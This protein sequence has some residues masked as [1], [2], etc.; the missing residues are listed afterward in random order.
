[1]RGALRGQPDAERVRAGGAHVLAARAAEP[2]HD[3][4]LPACVRVPATRLAC[5]VRTRARGDALHA[6]LGGVLRRGRRGGARADRAPQA[7]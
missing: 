1:V 7:G 5:F 3:R 4:R 2:H 6:Q